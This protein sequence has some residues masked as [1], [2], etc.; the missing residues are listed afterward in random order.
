MKKGEIVKGHLRGKDQAYHFIVFLDDQDEDTFIGG[1]LTHS[2]KY[3]DNILMK[4]DHFKEGKFKFENTHLVKG[5][6]FKLHIWGPFKKIGELTEDGLKFVDLHT[7]H[8]D[9]ILWED[10]IK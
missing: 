5:R 6:F 4:S 3:K 1:V 8:L 2:T 7:L 9:P 10:Y